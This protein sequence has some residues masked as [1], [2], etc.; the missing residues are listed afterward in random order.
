M[1][2]CY[3][4]SMSI[5]PI[6]QLQNIHK[7]FGAVTALDGMN[8]HVVP[9]EILAIVGDNG[10]GKSTLMKVG[11]GVIQPDQGHIVCNGKPLQGLQPKEAL[12]AGIS[13]V[14]QDL[15]L[16]PMRDCA[17]NIFLGKEITSFL[18]FIDHKSMRRKTEQL[19]HELSIHIPDITQPAGSLSGGQRQSLA[20]A[21]AM[22]EKTPIMFFDEPTSAMGVRESAK[23]LDLL[24]HLREEGIA[25]IIISHN[26]FQVFDVADRVTVMAAGKKVAD[27]LCSES[28][29]EEVNQ[30][31]LRGR[32]K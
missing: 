32:A 17:G 19:L 2:V 4:N 25:V 29:P 3:N 26:L 13:A 1:T 21:R 15:A 11:G 6:L 9:G 16:D 27:V 31:I 24:R 5:Q 28:T 30:F 20:I 23:I 14:Y 7:R 12:K 8:L 18:F 22:H 10:C